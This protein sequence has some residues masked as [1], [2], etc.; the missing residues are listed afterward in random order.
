[1][2]VAGVPNQPEAIVIE[3]PLVPGEPQGFGKPSS[4]LELLD[5]A[6][7]W[8]SIEL[9]P[10]TASNLEADFDRRWGLVCTVTDVVHRL[11]EPVRVRRHPRVGPLTPSALRGLAHKEVGMLPD[12]RPVV[13]AAASAGW[14]FG[15]IDGDTLVGRAG[16]LA[17]GARYADVGVHVAEQYRRQGIAVSAAS[18]ACDAVQR[19]GLTPVWGT[20]SQNE[21]SLAVAMRLGFVEVERLTYLVRGSA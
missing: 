10:G 13:E 11:D 17:A 9:D 7:G 4:I 5:R 18:R 14:L 6:D 21:A 15:T 16:V 3:S 19:S 12:N 20:G 2:W 8:S 1:M